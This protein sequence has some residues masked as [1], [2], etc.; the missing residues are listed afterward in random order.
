MDKSTCHSVPNILLAL[1]FAIALTPAPAWA[2][3]TISDPP[4]LEGVPADGQ[5]AVPTNV[6]MHYVTPCTEQTNE[7]PSQR[8][9]REYFLR[10][11]D[12]TR[13]ELSGKIISRLQVELTPSA[14][15][16][17]N[18]AYVLEAL[19][20]VPGGEVKKASLTFT[21]DLEPSD[22]IPEPPEAVWRNYKFPP[23]T[24]QS[25]PPPTVGACISVQDDGEWYEYTRIDGVNKPEPSE[26]R[27]GSFILEG[28]DLIEHA[29][30]PCFELRRFGANGARS[31][32]LQL[33]TWNAEQTD[34]TSTNELTLVHCSA[35]G[36]E[37]QYSSGNSGIEPGP[38][39]PRRAARP[40]SCS[41][42]SEP[43]ELDELYQPEL[44]P[45]AGMPETASPPTANGCSVSA[46]RDSHGGAALVFATLLSLGLARPRHKRRLNATRC[47][48]PNVL[49][50][51]GLAVA[52]TPA[53]A[54][55]CT[56][57][58]VTPRLQ[59]LPADGARDVPTNVVF[60]YLTPYAEMT[61]EDP[62]EV[63]QRE[64]TLRTA[65]GVLVALQ[66]ERLSNSQV[67]L[68]PN[69][70]LAPNTTYTLEGHWIAI[71]GTEA[72]AAISFET[73]DGPSDEMPEPPNAVLRSYQIA[74]KK[75]RA[76]G[77][78]LTGSC[79]SLQDDKAWFEYTRVAANGD[80]QPSELRQG[81]FL[82][83]DLDDLGKG[84]FP[85]AELRAFAPNG[86]RSQPLRLCQEDAQHA[87]LT[88][89]TD[90]PKLNC[91]ATGLEWCDASGKSGVEP[92]PDD[93]R[94]VDG[95]VYC[96]PASL[97]QAEQHDDPNQ[98][99]A[100]AGTGVDATPATPIMR[101]ADGCS[102]STLRGGR[103]ALTFVL[104][105]LATMGV[106]RGRRKRQ[107]GGPSHTP[108][109]PAR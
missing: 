44:E 1:C 94:N 97:A 26:L 104:A 50:A 88:D 8:I 47:S 42:V 16:A 10:T 98:V 95:A 63:L 34:L 59:G 54:W 43:K 96:E 77:P 70:P 76:C 28:L 89:L 56:E 37:W 46:P 101:A 27:R 81:S 62:A 58:P 109:R 19:W 32:P 51:L 36:L 29:R 99:E 61:N 9:R 103:G 17:P 22:E 18:T 4:K 92:G 52:L 20:T 93:P 13:V 100:D 7:E 15:L 69:A 31:Q 90:M 48:V 67:E 25:C 106:L 83:R 57:T 5:L 35:K 53:P 108:S 65:D 12:G 91:S 82:L 45:D 84:E 23:F 55:A 68:T 14:P 87:D 3:P 78:S 73:G 107:S 86:A 74:P 6:V 30:F 66:G 85:C 39:R 79:V 64:Y 38:A 80:T 49:L 24:R 33:C 72:D 60:H 40:S 105:M 75:M 102:V 21:T 11:A 2:C 41:P 71:D